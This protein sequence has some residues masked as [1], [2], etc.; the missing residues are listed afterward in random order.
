MKISF[1]GQ[2][3]IYVS[4]ERGE[5]IQEQLMIGAKMFNIDGNT[6]AASTI[7]AITKESAPSEW[8]RNS[9]AKRI[10]APK[11]ERAEV[12]SPGFRKFKEARQR[13]NHRLSA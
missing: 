7:S 8:G 10:T 11:H 1:I 12:D 6:Y 4:K 9:D 5:T 3:P 13:L 2:P